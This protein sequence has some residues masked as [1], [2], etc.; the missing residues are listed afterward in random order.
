MVRTTGRS[1][2]SCQQGGGNGGA[3]AAGSALAA[4]IVAWPQQKHPSPSR[5]GWWRLSPTPPV[6]RAVHSPVDTGGPEGS[7]DDS[8]KP[9]L[10][11]RA[12]P[13]APLSKQ[14]SSALE[15][16]RAV[17]LVLLSLCLLLLLRENQRRIGRS[18]ERRQGGHSRLMSKTFVIEIEMHVRPLLRRLRAA[19]LRGSGV[20][21]L[22]LSRGKSERRRRR[23]FFSVVGSSASASSSAA[24]FFFFF[25]S[26]VGSSS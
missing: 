15:T 7:S 16:M 22:G 10:P 23:T 4:V 2:S 5:P 19:V 3:A 11:S 26:V 18:G 21:L 14:Y 13:K 12:T 24:R 9:P 25:F 1:S 6:P 17:L 8:P 20:R